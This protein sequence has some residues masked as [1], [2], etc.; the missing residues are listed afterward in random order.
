MYERIILATDGSENA[1]RATES[2]IGLVKELKS[3]SVTIVHILLSAPSESEIVRAKFDLH[4][5][6]EEEARRTIQTTIQR[7][8]EEGIPYS[9]VVALGDPASEIIRY[10]E[11]EGAGLI[12]IG[13]RGLTALKGALIG[14]VSQKVAQ[15]AECPVMIVR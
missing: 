11:K 5:L 12:V 10:A 7:F 2:T 15:S 1:Q 14:S 9:L 13:S 6:L 3:A 8:E 4:H